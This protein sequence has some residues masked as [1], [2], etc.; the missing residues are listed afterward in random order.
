MDTENRGGTFWLRAIQH[1]HWYFQTPKIGKV[2]WVTNYS[3][4]SAGWVPDAAWVV[5]MWKQHKITHEDF[6][7]VSL[8]IRDNHDRRKQMVEAVMADER[9]QLFAKEQAAARQCIAEVAMIFKPLPDQIQWW[10]MQYYEIQERYYMLVLFGPSRT[11]KSRLGR[12]FY[13]RT[14]VIDVQH[15]AHPDMQRYVRGRDDAVLLDEV[16]SP[17][18]I[19]TNKKLLQAHIDGAKLGQSATQKF[20]YEVFLWRTPIILTTNNFD[21]ASYS[22]ADRNWIESNCIAVHIPEPVWQ[23]EPST[24]K[25][26]PSVGGTALDAGSVLPAG[27]V[28]PPPLPFHYPSLEEVVSRRSG[29]SSDGKGMSLHQAGSATGHTRTWLASQGNSKKTK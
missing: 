28:G 19:V 8:K 9:A 26:Q 13:A 7:A 23:S 5:S 17:E 11:G 1:G 4:W 22:V 20:T 3:A 12:S 24:P 14:L 21:Y 18:L 29:S 10:R 16:A 27:K 6:L 25:C 15:A 2:F